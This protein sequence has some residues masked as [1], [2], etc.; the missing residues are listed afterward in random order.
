MELRLRTSPSAA[1]GML[2]FILLLLAFASSVAAAELQKPTVE[3]FDRYIRL[4]D[5]RIEGELRDRR[6]FLWVDALPDAQRQ[7]A[8][9]QL[10]AAQ[11]VIERLET[12]DHG[13]S[14]DVPDGLIHHWIGTAF[15]PTSTLQKTVALVQDYD[16]HS[17]IY[18]PEVIRSKILQH[19]GNDFKVLLRFR[20]K[21]VITIVLDT[22][23]QVHYVPLDAGH[24]YS[25]SYTTR[26]NEV[27]NAGQKGEYLLAP[28]ED[29]GFMWRLN[30]YWRF[31]EKDGGVYVQCEAIS[32][33]RG[34]PTALKWLIGPFVTSVPKESLVN[35]LNATR[36]ALAK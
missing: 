10:K 35:T 29:H 19:N 16:R 15:I 31:Q 32:L 12:S 14:I 27:E 9:S 36:A 30:S 1:K 26:I 4:T 22:E 25:R 11:V 7:R 2:V 13:R 17:E 34:I 20:K 3:A 24:E 28:G 5:A 18:K 8:Y 23:H 6:L 33:T 21:K